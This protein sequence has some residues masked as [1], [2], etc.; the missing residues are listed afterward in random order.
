MRWKRFKSKGC[1]YYWLCNDNEL[2]ES[3][4]ILLYLYILLDMFLSKS[5]KKLQCYTCTIYT[6]RKQ[7][8]GHFTSIIK[9]DFFL[10]KKRV[11]DIVMRRK[12][13]KWGL[14]HSYVFH[15]SLDASLSFILLSFK[16]KCEL[17]KFYYE[18]N[19]LVYRKKTFI[20]KNVSA[21]QKSSLWKIIQSST[22]NFKFLPFIFILM[23]VFETVFSDP[24]Q[25][26][27]F[28]LS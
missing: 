25:L 17:E 10:L 24:R 2:K 11:I 27:Y 8:E 1:K 6:I 5:D 21:F 15:Y 14:I 20:L 19:A 28:L 3:F 23:Y 9:W 26:K 13:K 7:M 16:L 12:S 4:Q 18:K 22:L